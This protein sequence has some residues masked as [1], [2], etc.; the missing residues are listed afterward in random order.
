MVTVLLARRQPSPVRSRENNSQIHESEFSDIG[1][2]SNSTGRFKNP[3]GERNERAMERLARAI[4]GGDRTIQV[5]VPN[6]DGK[7]NADEYCDWKASLEAF[8]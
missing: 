4:E 1:T 5:K 2:Q 8:F 3:F 6:F 7:L